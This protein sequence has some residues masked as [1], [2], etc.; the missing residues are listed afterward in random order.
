MVSANQFLRDDMKSRSDTLSGE[1]LKST[2][3]SPCKYLA[4]ARNSEEV[5]TEA[6][7]LLR[8]ISTT[9]QRETAR[10][11]LRRLPVPQRAPA[12]ASPAAWQEE[13][14][15]EEEDAEMEEPMR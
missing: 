12:A 14:A 13:D 4:G 7:L 5:E 2:Q 10:A 8:S 15:A 6:T 9:L 3:P 1:F 11:V